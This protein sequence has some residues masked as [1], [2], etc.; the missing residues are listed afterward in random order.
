M[1]TVSGAMLNVIMQGNNRKLVWSERPAPMCLGC[2]SVNVRVTGVSGGEH[3]SFGISVIG[4]FRYR[5]RGMNLCCEG[6]S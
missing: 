5:A 6:I 3:S 2:L 4:G 1:S